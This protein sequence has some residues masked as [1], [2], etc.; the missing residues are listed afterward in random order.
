MIGDVSI[1]A[2]GPGDLE[3][4]E[5]LALRSKAHWGYDDAFLASCVGELRLP[6]TALVD[7]IVLVAR[8]KRHTCGFIRMGRD[9]PGEIEA[10]FVAPEAIGGGIGRKL[11]H[12]ALACS[13]AA[14]LIVVSDPHAEG[15][16]RRLGF[17]AGGSEPSGSIPGRMLP[18]LVFERMRGAENEA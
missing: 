11:F 5:A 13:N 12:S 2:A 10:L 8:H 3:A 14:R 6:A 9:D 4:L 16:Y 7:D 18:R 1:E 17:R 15:F